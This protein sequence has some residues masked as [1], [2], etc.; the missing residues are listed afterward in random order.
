[1]RFFYI[2][3]LVILPAIALAQPAPAV[4]YTVTIPAAL[5]APNMETS[6]MAKWADKIFM[7]P[8]YPDRF[9]NT[10]YCFDTIG[11]FNGI[12]TGD[13]QTPVPYHIT[14]LDGTISGI[15]VGNYQGIEATTADDNNNIYFS[16]E[17]DDINTPC[18]LVKGR[19][20][21]ANST[22]SLTTAPVPIR[23]PKP[24][25][26]AGFEAIAYMPDRGK[27][28]AFYEFNRDVA[29]AKA[30][31]IDTATLKVTDSVKFT[32]PLY[33]RLT[34][35]AYM[36]NGKFLGVNYH[37]K[38]DYELYIGSHHINAATN[39]MGKNPADNHFA[40]IIELTLQD[41]NITFS[42]KKIISF[43]NDNWEAFVPLAGGYL[44][45]ID[46]KPGNFPCRLAWFSGY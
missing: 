29:Q 5:R 42:Q 12:R 27:I 20:N 22:I 18:Y 17:T 3:A 39:E 15:G 44:M 26:N 46:G 11:I 7:V 8:Q 35:V 31:I 43:E 23:R 13:M 33:F 34:E 1:M 10:V 25:H 28:I 2:L 21:A 6:S 9:G 36:G 32:Y 45:A 40:R 24:V 37:W 4:E 14:N 30:Y 41:K 19:I 38:G 16:I